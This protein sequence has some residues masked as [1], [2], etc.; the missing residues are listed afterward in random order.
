MDKKFIYVCLSDCGQIVKVGIS[1]NVASRI[2]GLK[3]QAGQNLKVLFCS[4]EVLLSRALEVEK[5]VSAKFKDNIIKGKEWYNIKPLLIIEFLIKE[6]GIEPYEMGDIST[7]FPSWEENI[8]NYKSFKSG[9]EFQQ[10]KEKQTKGLY[11]IA[12]LDKDKFNYIGFCN[13]G[14]AKDFY[15]SNKMFVLMADN[16]IK[17]LYEIDKEALHTLQIS[18]RK[19]IYGLKS[20]ILKVKENLL[21]LLKLTDF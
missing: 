14:D 19:N 9:S 5:E 21:N 2:I 17:D 4:K 6:L 8:T 11:C 7:Q 20:E 10:I 3:T 1:Y 12:Y 15:N 16:I 18:S 13:Y